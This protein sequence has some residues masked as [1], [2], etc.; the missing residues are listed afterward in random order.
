MTRGIFYIG[1]HK[2]GSSSLQEYL[3]LN[4]HKLLERGI[5]HPFVEPDGLAYDH[6]RSALNWHP[7]DL[8]F[9]IKSPHNHIAYK[10]LAELDKSYKVPQRYRPLPPSS[11]MMQICR[12]MMEWT[13]AET[14]LLCSEVFIQFGIRAPQAVN[15]L[16]RRSGVDQAQVYAVLRRPDLYLASWQSQLLKFGSKTG[17]LSD[18]TIQRFVGTCHLD[19]HAA[20]APWQA[21]VG[22]GNFTLVNYAELR[23]QGGSIGHFTARYGIDIADPVQATPQNTGLPYAAYETIRRINAEVRDHRNHMTRWVGQRAATLD[24]P[25]NGQVELFG[26]D[27]RRWLVDRFRAEDAKLAALVGRE[28]FFDDL[29]AGLEVNP[30]PE[31]EASEAAFAAIRAAYLAQPKRRQKLDLTEWFTATTRLAG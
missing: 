8:T 7:T 29:E 16:L 21:R 30:V 12:S 24:L 3:T 14:L 25:P 31:A 2:T 6:A 18:D 4:A 15:R 28:R 13:G 11:T 22:E 19:F 10:M 9:K 17:R 23:A 27:N 5:C 20:V 1:G 26:Q